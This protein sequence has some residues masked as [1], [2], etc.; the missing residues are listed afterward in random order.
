MISLLFGVVYS[1]R[2]GM[3]KSLYIQRLA[4]K[5]TEN[6][7]EYKCTIARIPIHGPSVSPSA[8]MRQ[9]TEECSQD[10]SATHKQ[11]IHLDVSHSVSLGVH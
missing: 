8:I 7:V 6:N 2:P 10:P 9:L 1:K 3:G 5:L 11:I 4:E